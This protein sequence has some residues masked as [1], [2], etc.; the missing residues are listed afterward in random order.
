MNPKDRGAPW[1]WDTRAV[2]GEA[3]GVKQRQMVV[4]GVGESSVG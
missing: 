2:E 3:A 4:S 1:S